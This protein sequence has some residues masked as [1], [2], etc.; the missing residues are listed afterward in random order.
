MNNMDIILAFIEGFALI[1]S[2]CILPILPIVLSVGIDG[3]KQR[4]YGLILGFILIF[5]AF[6][7]LSRKL[8]LMIGIEANLIRDISFIILLVFGIVML[9]SFLYEKTSFL[10]QRLANGMSK[11]T[12]RQERDGFW[13]GFILGMFIGL[14]WSPCVGPIIAVVLVQTIRQTTDL[15]AV[16]LLGAFS[17]G[18]GMPML[19]ITLEGKRCLLNLIFLKVMQHSSVKY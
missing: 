18:V 16:L 4:P 15:R 17:F 11:Q 19:L 1:V 7:L 14:I 5:W 12:Q 9:S 6:T 13:N 3:G 8:V 10:M 2:P